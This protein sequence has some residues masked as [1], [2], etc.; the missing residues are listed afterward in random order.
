[1]E[2]VENE[3]FAHPSSYFQLLKLTFYRILPG[4]TTTSENCNISLLP[5][6]KTTINTQRIAIV[7]LL[8]GFFAGIS[9][10]AVS[11]PKKDKSDLQVALDVKDE[12]CYHSN[13]VQITI[14]ATEDPVITRFS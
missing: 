6:M 5:L 2:I 12:T 9:G 1:M 3:M 14:T 10:T 8:V 13:D 7:L 11:Q 4:K